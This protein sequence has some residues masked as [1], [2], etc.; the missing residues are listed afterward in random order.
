MIGTAGDYLDFPW[1]DRYTDMFIPLSRTS[2]ALP[3]QS[4]AC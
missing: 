3:V 2:Y 4:R 1:N